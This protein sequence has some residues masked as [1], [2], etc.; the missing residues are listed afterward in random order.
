MANF[1]FALK[2]SLGLIPT[3]EKIEAQH[4]ALQADYERYQ[5]I[6]SSEEFAEYNT[7]K[8]YILSDSFKTSKK[9][10]T[11]LKYKSTEQ[12]QKEK[13]Y[14]K[15]AKKEAKAET[16]SEAYTELKAY[17][18]SEEFTSFKAYATD[19]NRYSQTEEAEKENRFNTLKNSEDIKWFLSHKDSSKYAGL[20][21]WKL[22]F[23]DDFDSGKIDEEK[24]MNS[25]FWGKML[26]ND[27]YVLAGEKHF[28]TDNKNA[29]L[30][31]TTV[32]LVTKNEETKGKVWHPVHGFHEE[33]FAY[34][35][36]MLCTAHSFRQQYG[37]FEAKVK[38]DPS[39]P[40]YQ[41]FWLK[42]EKIVPEIDVFKFNMGKK[43]KMEF[44]NHWQSE[45]GQAI[46]NVKSGALTNKYCIYSV[47]WTPDAIKWFI[48]GQLVHSCTQNIPEEPLYI[49]LSSGIK[50]D[51]KGAAINAAFEIDWVRCYEKA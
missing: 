9:K 47:E 40:V 30:N 24:W 29:E 37:K 33:E 35:S 45:N 1:G 42:G 41:A 49:V 43:N 20:N 46:S 26:L 15:L 44:A 8:E 17:V 5:Q 50:A 32:K 22:T 7:L 4:S 51:P 31:G 48:N 27:R 11:S 14:L 36:G 25:Y 28:Y 2:A 39:F 3:A 18:E 38:L 21:T 34:T 16:P 12:Y 13:A 23:E 19:K 6:E 10:I